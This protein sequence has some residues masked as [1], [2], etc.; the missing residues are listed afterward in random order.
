MSGLGT[1]SLDAPRCRPFS[2]G[3]AMILIATTAVGFALIQERLGVILG[4]RMLL[5]L[6]ATSA[7][8]GLILEYIVTIM[9][10]FL[11]PATLG[12][13]VIR[14]R[15]PRPSLDR[16]ALQPGMVAN[17][18]M[19]VIIALVFWLEVD[20]PALGLWVELAVLL[21]MPLSW[22]VLAVSGRWRREPGWI[23]RLGVWVGAGWC[24]V[25]G[26]LMISKC[27]GW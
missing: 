20:Q 14:L 13:L 16:I 10:S 26:M 12:Y 27:Q 8:I 24:L 6:L 19:A 3:D 4:S 2:I 22:I 25:T 21:V 1:E 23:D 17:A 11:M 15:R 5:R 7:G 18:A 9:S